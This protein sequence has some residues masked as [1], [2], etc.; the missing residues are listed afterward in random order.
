MSARAFIILATVLVASKVEGNAGLRG[1]VLANELSGPPMGNAEVSAVAGNPNN[2]GA[3]GKFTFTFPNRNPGNTV[4]LIVRKERYV[5]VN[6][7]QL[8]LTLPSDPEER[9]AIILLCKEWDREEM[10]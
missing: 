8:E 5:V 9:P 7:I 2:T 1:V 4:R 6:D 3:D 10:A